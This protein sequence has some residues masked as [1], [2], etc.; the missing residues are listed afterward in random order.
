MTEGRE[1]GTEGGREGGDEGGSEGGRE[2]R[3]WEDAGKD[4]GKREGKEERTGGKEAQSLV[5]EGKGGF[6]VGK[7]SEPRNSFCLRKAGV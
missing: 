3:G 7:G 4:E 2:E 1:R 5:P 6:E